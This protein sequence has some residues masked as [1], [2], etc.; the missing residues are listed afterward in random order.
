MSSYSC[1]LPI[2]WDR[3]RGEVLPSWLSLLAGATTAADF[4]AKHIQLG[5]EFIQDM[6][7]HDSYRAPLDY[8]AIFTDV[9][10][11]GWETA[12]IIESP[13]YNEF[14][15]RADLTCSDCLLEAA[16]KQSS[17]V[18][19]PGIDR[20]EKDPYNGY[21]SRLMGKP[22]VQV[23]GTKNLYH[24]LNGMFTFDW[25]PL[26]HLYRVSRKR[27]PTSA[28]FAL[29]ESLFLGVRALPGVSLAAEVPSWSATDDLSFAG[30]LAP[31]GSRSGGGHFG[32]RRSR[33]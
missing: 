6:C 19:L 28:M 15:Q 8:L 32:T 12:S 27:G 18:Q 11:L 23:A 20:F 2:D 13:A 17:A 1:V 33:R 21:Y 25:H 7:L 4:Y 29:L 26:S 10:P 9:S 5:D 16:I 22:H 3:L 24:F 14:T 30:Y 31:E